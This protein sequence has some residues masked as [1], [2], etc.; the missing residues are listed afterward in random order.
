MRTKYYEIDAVSRVQGNDL[1]GLVKVNT[2][3]IYLANS[4]NQFSPAMNAYT[5]T[6]K[7]SQQEE[8]LV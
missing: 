8:I 6:N 7:T 2:F 1:T 4:N 5:W 3:Y